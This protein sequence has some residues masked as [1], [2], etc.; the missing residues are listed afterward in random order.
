MRRWSA[1]TAHPPRRG[2]APELAEPEE[3]L[4]VIVAAIT[5]AGYIPGRTGIA[6]ALDPAASEF[7]HDDG[8]YHVNGQLLSSHDMV[9]RYAAMVDRYPIWSIEDGLGESDRE[10]WQ[11]LTARIGG[12]VQ[13]VGDDY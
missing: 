12:R 5:D 1:P 7:L 2:F 10:G 13:L 9:E 8:N 6:I 11:E 4:E 3:V